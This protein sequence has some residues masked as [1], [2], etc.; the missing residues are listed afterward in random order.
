MALVIVGS[1]SSN[2]VSVSPAFRDICARNCPPAAISLDEFQ[3]VKEHATRV[4]KTAISS[5]EKRWFR[6]RLYCLSAFV[7]VIDL[8]DDD[9]VNHRLALWNE[10]TLA[11]GQRSEK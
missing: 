10:R 9:F 6:S 8:P 11:A 4:D 5:N 3:F 1:S 2:N 7:G